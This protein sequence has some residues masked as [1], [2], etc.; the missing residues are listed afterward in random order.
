MTELKSLN[1][2]QLDALSRPLPDEAVSPHPTKKYLSSIK[3]I[4]VTER[5]NEVFGVGK[6]R[7]ETEIIERAD[8]M[9]VVKLKFSIPDYG[10]YYECYGGIETSHVC[11]A[12]SN[13][14]PG[15]QRRGGR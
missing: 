5:L 3:S 1:S 7:I 12:S 14:P 11:G 8:K 2:T 4:Y 15:G 9:V 10:I 13:A 6:W